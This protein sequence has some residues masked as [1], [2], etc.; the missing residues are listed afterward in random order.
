MATLLRAKDVT[1]KL[2]ESETLHMDSKVEV[3]H[4]E[5]R[6][7]IFTVPTCQFRDEWLECWIVPEKRSIVLKGKSSRDVIPQLKE[8]LRNTTGNNRIISSVLQHWKVADFREK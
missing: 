1:C 4:G 7:E 3:L 2:A 6:R 5:E 8:V